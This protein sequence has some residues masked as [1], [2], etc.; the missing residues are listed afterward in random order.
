[1]SVAKTRVR[2]RVFV[3]LALVAVAAGVPILASPASGACYSTGYA[4]SAEMRFELPTSDID[5]TW[6]RTGIYL[7]ARH[8][9]GY[10][11]PTLTKDWVRP[12]GSK[13]M[14]T[15]GWTARSAGYSWYE[16]YVTATGRYG[17]HVETWDGFARRLRNDEQAC[18]S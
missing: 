7:I 3:V 6:N 2:S 5:I 14:Q 4:A 11:A 8:N 18:W 13:T 15:A 17:G 10:S 12:V 16:K 1:M 9:T